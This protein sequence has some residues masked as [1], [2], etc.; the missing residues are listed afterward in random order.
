MKLDRPPFHSFKP[1]DFPDPSQFDVIEL[2]Y[3]GWWG[4]LVI[5]NGVW[6]IYSRT[7]MLKKEGAFG[8]SDLERTVIH[9]EFLYGTEWAKD[10]PNLYEKLACHTAVIVNGEDI[11]DW[12][13]RVMRE[14]LEGFL[15]V[16]EH[17]PIVQRCFVVDQIPIES[18][19]NLW[20]FVLEH[21][22]EGLIFKNS[23]APWGSDMGR[24]KRGVTMDYV[25]MDVTP[26]TSATY[27]GWGAKSLQGGLYVDGE[28]VKRCSV[29]GMND[30]QRREFL[31]NKDKYVGRV[32][33]CHGKKISKKGSVRHP[34]F[35]RW[36]DD[37]DPEDCTWPV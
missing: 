1:G 32:F 20:D 9:S 19:K 16:Y 2:K 10:R 6:Q 26:S 37:K 23:E 22:Y 25:L 28:L 27:S 21:D 17:E 29:P 15:T 3:D 7:G 11:T 24:M 30:E 5:E 35:I 8:D 33:E 36:R 34:E 13:N 31:Q 4:Q 14:A 12:P 18:G